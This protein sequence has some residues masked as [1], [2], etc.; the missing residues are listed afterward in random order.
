MGSIDRGMG[1]AALGATVSAH[2]RRLPPAQFDSLPSHSQAMILGGFALGFLLFGGSKARAK[3]AE[4]FLRSVLSASA[5]SALKSMRA[6][7]QREE[8]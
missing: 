8:R 5:V 7:S 3:R 2:I 4:M 6:I 1:R